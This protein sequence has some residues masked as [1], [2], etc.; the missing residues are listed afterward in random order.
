MTEMSKKINE[1]KKLTVTTS[2][3]MFDRYVISTHF[4]QIGENYID[5]MEKYVKP[6]YED[7]DM[8][9][10]SSKVI[11]LCQKRVI[12]KSSVKLSCTAKFLS[13]FATHSSAG[14]GMDSP[15]K[16]QV[17]LD[18]CGYPK[19]LFAAFCSGVTKLF[20]KHGVFYKIAGP[21]VKGLDGFYDKAFPEYG[22][23]G[24]RLP[25][26]STAVCNEI[27]EKT[28]ILAAVID[29][30]DHEGDILG[31][32][33]AYPIT[34][35]QLMEIIKDNPAGQSNQQTPITLIIPH[36]QEAASFSA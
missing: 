1:G 34:K 32:A 36:K 19:I 6:E 13:R 10:I 5:L 8:I 16:L 7:G 21:E 22:E 33:D 24:I 11:S 4:V 35:D 12:Y 15:Y 31:M 28:G 2:C 9:T 25:E 27:Y 26:N 3:G 29:V 17:A 23:F 18:Y 14:I 30:N 20:H